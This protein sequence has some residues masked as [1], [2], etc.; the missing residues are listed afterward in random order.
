MK[1]PQSTFPILLSVLLIV[2][3]TIIL[4]PVQVSGLGPTYQFNSSFPDAGDDGWTHGGGSHPA[5]TTSQYHSTPR[6]MEFQS[7]ATSYIERSITPDTGNYQFSCWL[8]LGGTY[9]FYGI[10]FFH[11]ANMIGPHIMIDTN[12]VLNRYNHSSSGWN[13]DTGYDVA[14]TT[15]TKVFLNVLA[16]SNYQDFYLYVN[17]A[18]TGKFFHGYGDATEYPTTVK[19][20]YI[21]PGYDQAPYTAYVDDI[22]F[23]HDMTPTE[24]YVTETW[25]PTFTNS[26]V[27]FGYYNQNYQY[28]PTLN[29]SATL[30]AVSL[31]GWCD[32]FTG[33]VNGTIPDWNVQYSFSLKAV[34]IA[35]GGTTWKNWTIDT[36]YSPTESWLEG[37]DHR[38]K[39]RIDQGSGLSWEMYVYITNDSLANSGNYIY[40]DNQCNH[41]FSDIRFTEVD[42]S[43]P[44][45]YWRET[46]VEDTWGLF[47]FKVFIPCYFY[48]YY[49]NG[50]AVTTSNGPATFSEFDDFDGE[51]LSGEWTSRG[52]PAV[53]DSKVLL[54]GSTDRI[55]YGTG[56]D[57][58]DLALRMK[59]TEQTGGY[60]GYGWNNSV[61]SGLRY[62]VMGV[63]VPGEEST[64]GV[65]NGTWDAYSI[66]LAWD[67]TNE[68]VY[69]IGVPHQ[70][71][72]YENAY[73]YCKGAYEK[74]ES[75][76][77]A[78]YYV[79]QNL[80]LIHA[81]S[82]G[83]G[84]VEID[85][86]LV[87]KFSTEPPPIDQWFTEETMIYPGPVTLYGHGHFE[88]TEI[89]LN[90]TLPS[91][92]FSE[93]LGYVLFRSTDGVTYWQI[94]LIPGSESRNY[95]DSNITLVQ[96]FSYYV[97]AYNSEGN[98]TIS[99]IVTINWGTQS[100]DI[101][102]GFIDKTMMIMAI[103]IVI[104][105]LIF[106]GS[107]RKGGK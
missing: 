84:K 104:G 73:F 68:L 81:G 79:G 102:G 34:S 57:Y 106:V 36:Y 14:T 6:S 56:Y 97:T 95:T 38:L 76:R 43:T 100:P 51:S 54:E 63:F 13:E 16:S 62:D 74:Y 80:S 59:I 15:W 44:V 9:P 85:W 46:Y 31:P 77:G 69:D 11:D 28:S 24:E 64:W 12:N 25:G 52:S 48:I 4:I 27:L 37:W 47:W 53:Y 5:T 21:F 33:V 107:I 67:G 93:T 66:P 55:E 78:V 45:S 103:I 50:D 105:L 58:G 40:I 35:G 39:G 88:L 1:V 18:S 82:T 72:Y 86:I 99:N 7:W 49:G 91:W 92:Q 60:A 3:A 94:A 90:W 29:E 83:S 2:P 89:H 30:T 20:G 71:P 41:D 17:N 19:I 42:G 23:G 32:A 10:Q 101:S 98:G 96:T 26:P 22:K 87:R 75:Y 70:F 65:A 61:K 8:R